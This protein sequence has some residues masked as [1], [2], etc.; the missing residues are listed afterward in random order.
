MVDNMREYALIIAL[1][2]LLGCLI[3]PPP[4]NET[5]DNTTTLTPIPTNVSDNTS[6]QNATMNQTSSLPENY[7]VNFGDTVWVNYTLWVDD[8]VID[9][10]NETL[11]REEGIYNWARKYE[12]F[13]FEVALN[14][15]LIDGFI[16]N[17]VGMTINETISFKVELAP[18]YYN[19]SNFEVVPRSYLEAQGINISIGSGY[20]TP[21]GTVF[22]NETN[23]ENVTLFYLLL[24]GTN[25][26]VNNIPQTVHSTHTNFTVTIEYLFEMNETYTIPDPQTG[27]S[28]RYTVIDKTDQNITLDANH[29]LANDTLKFEVTL[30]EA[31]RPS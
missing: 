18:R 9:T 30:I 11:A 16:L 1:V 12:P 14:E 2:F 4:S 27:L 24:Q 26:T 6:T 21:Y 17:V 29:P 31:T 20:L 7:F 22:I 3:T 5:P 8:K 10:N 15:G 13:K 19:R 28:T 25:F 23:E